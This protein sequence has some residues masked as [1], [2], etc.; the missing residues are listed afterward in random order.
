MDY[1]APITQV[2]PITTIRREWRLPAPGTVAVRVNEQLDA[3]EI[4]AEA[5]VPE[6]HVLLDVPRALNVPESTALKLMTCEVGDRLSAGD[7]IAEV[8][9]LLRRSVRA[10]GNGRVIAITGGR[11]LF[12]IVGEL[13]ELRARF[14]CVVGGTDGVQSIAVETSGAVIQGVWGNGKHDYGVLRMVGTE[15]GGIMTPASVDIGLRGSILV[16]GSCDQAAPL[17]QATELS[18][19]GLILGGLSS[20]LIPLARRMDYPIIVLEGFGNIAINSAAYQ[21]LS[22]NQGKEASLDA[23]PSRPYE[24]HRPEIIIPLPS[25][26]RYDLSEE[27]VPLSPGVR[28][29]VLRKPHMG[30]VGV[31]S[32]LLTRAE[33]YPSG[34]LARSARLDLE[35]TGSVVVPLANLEVL[36]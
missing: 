22:T 19:R 33:R 34:N 15:P 28:V 1:I 9:G 14:P 16:A 13:Y 18:V 2:S 11:V 30:A 23:K 21:L 6:R 27:I 26:Q 8:S 36:K 20:S 35:G 32:E 25:S 24:G 10:P 29:R 12:E 17:H 5:E 3:R 31:V 4:V 7:R